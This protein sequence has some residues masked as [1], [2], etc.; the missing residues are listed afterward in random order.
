MSSWRDIVEVPRQINSM[1]STY[2]K[3][4]LN[5]CE[6]GERPCVLANQVIQVPC[7]YTVDFT[8]AVDGFKPGLGTCGD[9]FAITQLPFGCP[10][11]RG[12][13]PGNRLLAA[14]PLA[15]SQRQ[16]AQCSLLLCLCSCCC[17][18]CWRL[19]SR[20]VIGGSDKEHIDQ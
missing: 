18:C 11:R 20:G 19:S 6:V 7:S 14:I 2:P 9:A 10:A 5:Q 4:H 1:S 17:C 15:F 3:R 13:Y 12:K 8:S 16:R